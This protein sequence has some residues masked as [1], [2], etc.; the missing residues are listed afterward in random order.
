MRTPDRG[1]LWHVD[2]DP[3]KGTEQ[4]G[5][6]LVFIVSPKAFNAGGLALVWIAYRLLL[7]DPEEGNGA[8]GAV[9]A[10]AFFFGAR[11]GFFL[12]EALAVT[13]NLPPSSR[14]WRSQ[15]VAEGFS[16]FP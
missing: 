12:I 9:D 10:V 2:L 1:E 13:Y 7:P 14:P 6:R 15:D 11:S 3:T 16:H 4:R 5:A 8:A